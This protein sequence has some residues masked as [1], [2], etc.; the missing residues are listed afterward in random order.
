MKKK[1]LK[2]L[3]KTVAVKIKKCYSLVVFSLFLV[4]NKKYQKIFYKPKNN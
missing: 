3:F 1:L 4:I 2:Q